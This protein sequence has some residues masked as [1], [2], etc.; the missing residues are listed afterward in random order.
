MYISFISKFACNKNNRRQEG[1]D[2]S[3]RW[4]QLFSGGDLCSHCSLLLLAVHRKELQELQNL[5]KQNSAHTAQQAELIRQLQVL[6]TDT[7]K[8]LKNQEDAHTAESISY[9][10]VRCLFAAKIWSYVHELRKTDFKFLKVSYLIPFSCFNLVIFKF[11]WVCCDK[12]EK[13][14][15]QL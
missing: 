14:K 13:L 4:T 9:Q 2:L 3:I 5:Y 6:N 8:V 11:L 15:I 12:L 10:K 7:Q 1:A